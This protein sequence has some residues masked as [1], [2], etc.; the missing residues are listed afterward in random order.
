[1]CRT[2]WWTNIQAQYIK[3]APQKDEGLFY[4]M[5]RLKGL[6]GL[7]MPSPLRGHPANCADV[8]NR[9]WRFFRT[10]WRT[11]S[12]RTANN[13]KA[14]QKDEGLFYYM[15]RLKGFEPLTARFVAEYSIQLSYRR[16]ICRYAARDALS[17]FL[18]FASMCMAE[19]EGLFGLSCPHRYSAHRVLHPSG[20]PDRLFKFDPVEFVGAIRRLREC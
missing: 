15:A 16:I 2:E 11:N 20:Q 10:E 17:R 18:V 14:P 3:K 13:K 5:A 1:M 9:S 19:K 8:K 6:F 4:Y 12:Y 7:S